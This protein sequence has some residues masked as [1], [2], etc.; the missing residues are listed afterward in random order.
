[1]SKY[2]NPCKKNTNLKI[3]VIAREGGN[4]LSIIFFK[5]RSNIMKY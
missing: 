1:M 3:V 2:K 4:E 5:E